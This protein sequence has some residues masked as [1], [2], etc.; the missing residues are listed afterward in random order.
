MLSILKGY[1]STIAGNGISG[2]NDGQGTLAQFSFPFCVTMDSIGNIYVG[3]ACAIR[4]INITGF[5]WENQ[6]KITAG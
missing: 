3:D 2:T 1:V 4:V 6:S 5:F